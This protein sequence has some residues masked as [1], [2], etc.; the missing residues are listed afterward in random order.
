MADVSV[1]QVNEDSGNSRG[2]NPRALPD[3]GVHRHR[4]HH[5]LAVYQVRIQRLSGR[6]IK[7]LNTSGQQR[8]SQNMPSFHP[9]Q[10]GQRGQQEDEAAGGQLGGNDQPTFVQSVGKDAA[11]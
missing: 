7:S 9:A 3:D 1:D 5:H 6:V 10:Q 11:K 4:T 2:D 8:D